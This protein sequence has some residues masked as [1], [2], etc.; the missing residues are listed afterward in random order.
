MGVG[1]GRQ[2]SWEVAGKCEVLK[3]PECCQREQEDSVAEWAKPGRSME[4]SCNLLSAEAESRE[5]GGRSSEKA[6]L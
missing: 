2:D 6:G 1:W 4:H 5:D 3:R